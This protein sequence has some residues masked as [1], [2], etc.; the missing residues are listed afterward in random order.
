MKH[1][2]N[3]DARRRTFVRHV[4]RIARAE[5]VSVVG[6]VKRQTCRVLAAIRRLDGSVETLARE[7]AR[8]RRPRQSSG[9]ENHA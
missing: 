9:T 5:R 4:E 6:E 1:N 2:K 7:L 3:L 8:S